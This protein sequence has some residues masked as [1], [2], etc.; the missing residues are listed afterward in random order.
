MIFIDSNI[1]MYLV[2]APHPNKMRA[3]ELLDKF[4]DSNERLVSDC[5]ILQEILH[6]YTAIDRRDAIQP[7]FDILMAVVDEFFPLDT[8]DLERA[9][10]IVLTTNL[11]ARDSLHLAVMRHQGV[12]RILTFDSDFDNVAD[13]SRLS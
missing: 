10:G 12:D 6:R 9:K 1:P 2:G 5:E 4:F 11:S 8:E 13:I 7:A 3:R